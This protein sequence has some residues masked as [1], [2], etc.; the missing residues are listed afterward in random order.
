MNRETK[1]AKHQAKRLEVVLIRPAKYDGD[2]YVVRHYRGV[3][4]SNTLCCLY[5]LTE[6]VAESARFTGRVEIRIHVYDETVDRVVPERIARRFCRPSSRVLVGLVGVQTNQFPRAADLARRFVAAGCKVMIGGFHV[7]GSLA[8]SEKIPA[9]CQELL[10]N[11][12]T[13]VKGEVE[14]VWGD[15]LEDVV[16]DRME[17]IYDIVERPALESAPIPKIPPGYIRRF[18]YKRFGTLDTGRGCPFDCSFCTVINVQGRKMRLRSPQSILARIRENYNRGKGISYYILADDNVARNRYWEQIFDGLIRMR[19]EEGVRIQFIMQIDVPAYRIPNFVQKASEAGCSQVFVGVESL[20]PKNLEAANKKQNVV[21]DYVAMVEAWQGVGVHFHAAYIIGFP[22]DTY[23]SIMADVD[24]LAHEMKVD[25]VSFFILTP[26]PGSRDHAEAVAAGIPM[27]GDLNRYDSFH[28]VVDHPN[29]G[30]EQWAAAY[31][32]AWKRFYTFENMKEILLRSRV[33]NYWGMLKGFL[34]YRGGMIEGAH[35]LVT[36]FFRLKDRKE[37]RPGY[38]IDPW[39]VHLR[40]RGS[41]VRLLLREWCKLFFELQELWLQTR[42]PTENLK[43]F[44][45]WKEQL[46]EHLTEWRRNLRSAQES[47]QLSVGNLR[48]ALEQN[49]ESL[50]SALPSVSLP[51][52]TGHQLRKTGRSWWRWL[53]RTLDVL[54]LHGVSTRRHLDRFWQETKRSLARKAFWRINPFLI[55]W[56]FLRDLRLSLSFTVFMLA[57][58]FF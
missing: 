35:P 38:P 43:R 44:G 48:T 23:E 45:A 51:G 36:G 41:E 19:R 54:S 13:L 33:H 39:W 10:D 9:E 20:N 28:A 2:G 34:W 11:G 49:I 4:P 27:D 12:V 52:T 50:R 17:P 21:K 40:K 3:L 14:N 22:H 7:S 30:R 6:T 58:R 32:D 15:L 42:I 53:L 18:V 46:G 8:M 55:F 56:N 37:R 16:E 31:R 1:R 57:E 25:Q 24:T 47:I 26:L 5:G 29:M